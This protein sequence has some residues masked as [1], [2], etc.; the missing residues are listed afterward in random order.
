[1]ILYFKFVVFS[2]GISFF[3]FVIFRL[4]E[5]VVYNDKIEFYL[6]VSICKFYFLKYYR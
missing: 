4:L 3:L 6:K 5:K 2:V 1:M